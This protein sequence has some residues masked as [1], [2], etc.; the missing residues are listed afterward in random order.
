MK[1]LTLTL[2]VIALLLTACTGTATPAPTVEPATQAETNPSVVTA[3][4]KL[5]PAPAVELAFAQGGVVAEVLAQPGDKVAAGEVLARLIGIETVQAELA[6]GKLEQV[7]A[8]VV[9]DQ[10]Q[11]NALLTAS[12]SEKALLD[13]QKAYES[14]SNGWNLGNI[15][16]ATD[17]E[18]TLDDY[19]TAEQDYRD[20]RD[21]LTSLLDKDETNRERKDAQDDFDSEKKAL[22]ETYA[23]LLESI[24]DN[25]QPLDEEQ[26]TLLNAIA[27]LEVARQNQSRLDAQN[28]DP[29]KLA[30]AEARLAAA[31]THVTA[32]EAALELY[33][34]RAPF[35]GTVL[36]FD[37]TAG[38]A[39][40]PGLPVAF[41]ADTAVWTVETKDL[42]E[43]DIA[44]VSLGQTASIKLDA[45]PGE[46]F[47]A[48]V[49]AIDPVGQ[50]YLG[51]MT[52]KVTLTLDEGDPR[53]MWNMTAT[54]N[55]DV[56]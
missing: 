17:L 34:L 19:V 55:V 8:Q 51:D 32:A 41:L 29:E 22:A 4:G 14:E 5:L 40:L 44:S 42:A 15:D 28:L 23:D 48:T 24:A 12:Q 20:A 37:L 3:E 35:A 21:K 56:K 26:V 27:A 43:I 38:E 6:A 53:F 2:A 16:D 31:T 54:V 7:N 46:E 13:A 25:D 18:L 47:P 45:F 1:K 52:Y 10:L 33:E 49:T 39:A 36:S 30:A 50:E 9:L 11:R